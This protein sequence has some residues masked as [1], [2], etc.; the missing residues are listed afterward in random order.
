MYVTTVVMVINKDLFGK[1]LED[2]AKEKPLG[3][4]IIRESKK[5]VLAIVKNVIKKI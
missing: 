2:V 4:Q 5:G 3:E 1:A